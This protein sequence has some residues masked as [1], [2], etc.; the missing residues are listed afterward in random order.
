[1]RIAVLDVGGTAIKSGIWEDGHIYQF[2]EDDTDAFGGGAHLLECMIQI[3]HGL[4]AENADAIGVSTTGQI[5]TETGTVYYANDNIPGY[6]GTEI[7][8]RLREEFG[9]PV[10][11][12]NDVNAAALGEYY[13]GAAKGKDDFLCLTYGTG[14]GGAIVLKGEVYEGCNWAA[15]SFGGI[16]I[17]PEQRI[18]G[19]QLSGCYESCASTA[20]L[21]RRAE[22][23]DPKL[24]D[25]R[26]IFWA[27]DRPEVKAEIDAWID[28]I[29][30]G[31]ITLIHIFDVPALILGGGVMAQEYVLKE[32]RRRTIDK[33]EENF[34]NVEILGAGLGNLAGMTGAAWLA[35]KKM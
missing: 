26:K 17:H 30:Y 1:M 7:G 27:M 34:K 33:V 14:V 29:T 18:A 12:E 25:G 21:V 28:E 35:Q 22:R 13:A 6:T 16:L 23:V 24:T 19:K 10:A 9:V 15:A 8:K 11:V 3:L 20:A 2:A 4:D 5:N 32:V 31:L